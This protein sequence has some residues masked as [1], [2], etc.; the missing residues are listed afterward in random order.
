M[1]RD[2]Y[3]GLSQAESLK[4]SAPLTGF[5]LRTDRNIKFRLLIVLLLLLGLA[6]ACAA[7]K[8]Q[9]ISAL[10]QIKYLQAQGKH[11]QA[12]DNLEEYLAKH[13]QSPYAPETAYLIGESYMQLN[14]LEKAQEAYTKL[15][16]GYSKSPSAALGWR[17]LAQLEH[18]KGNFKAAIEN[19][20]HSM[21]I[22]AADFN[23]ERCTLHI[24]RIYEKDL[25][26]KDSALK[27]YKKLLK[28]LKNP[29]IASEAHLA[30]AKI[31]LKQNNPQEAHSVLEKLLELY[32][33]SKQ[34]EEA[35][36]LLEKLEV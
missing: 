26:D 7:P 30:A 5:G 15:V 17:R 18:K 14:Q 16:Y 4:G 23:L 8:K 3:F 32:P 13:S 21:K 36:Q 9:K 10:P 25:K 1:S 22:Y 31:Y 6:G 20:Q 29:R 28:E 34:A 35:K 12:I 24:A 33:K 19:Y 2:R 27:E 11:E